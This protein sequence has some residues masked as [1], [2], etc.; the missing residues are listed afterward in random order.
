[1]LES[2]GMRLDWGNQTFWWVLQTSWWDVLVGFLKTP[3]FLVEQFGWL[4]KMKMF[5]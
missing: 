4:K 1:M 3:N 5:F 2:V